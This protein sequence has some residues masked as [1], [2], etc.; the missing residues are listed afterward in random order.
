M[1]S[2]KIIKQACLSSNT[3]VS[4]CHFLVKMQNRLLSR[5]DQSQKCMYFGFLLK[6]SKMTVKGFFFFFKA[7][8]HNDDEIRKEDKNNKILEFRSH[9]DKR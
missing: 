6:P 8:T 7:E 4:T 3:P 5:G 2:S 1:A 9:I